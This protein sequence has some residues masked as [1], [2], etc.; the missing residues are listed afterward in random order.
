LQ[1]LEVIDYSVATVL[2]LNEDVELFPLLC[3]GIDMHRQARDSQK[4]GLDLGQI[5]VWMQWLDVN[6]CV[7]VGDVKRFEVGCAK[8]LRKVLSDSDVT[9]GWHISHVAEH[10]YC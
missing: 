6:A 5:Q 1:S 7:V 8:L 4:K 9:L 3:C 10:Q 2:A